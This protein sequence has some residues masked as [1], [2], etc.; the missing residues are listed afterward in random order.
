MNSSIVKKLPSNILD[1]IVIADQSQVLE[2]F[3]DDDYTDD[4]VAS[5]VE[6]V[7]LLCISQW[8]VP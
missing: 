5:L 1:E 7:I 4:D 3:E 2:Y 8:L 6:Q